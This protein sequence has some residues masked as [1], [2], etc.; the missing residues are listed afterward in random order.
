M[1]ADFHGR[2]TY[3]FVG[4]VPFR[5]ITSLPMDE[6]FELIKLSVELDGR[7]S[8]LTELIQ[9]VI[10]VEEEEED[11]EEEEEGE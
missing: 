5:I 4:E 11:E 6:P 10:V 3:A 1:C 8:Q 2:P 7:T 9:L